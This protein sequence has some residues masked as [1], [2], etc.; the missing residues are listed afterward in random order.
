MK[1]YSKLLGIFSLIT[2]LAALSIISYC[3]FNGKIHR[4]HF[5]LGLLGLYFIIHF[6]I[7]NKLGFKE[8]DISTKAT[9]GLLFAASTLFLIISITAIIPFVQENNQKRKIETLSKLKDFGKDENI[10][11]GTFG[12]LKTKYENDNL[13]Y[14]LA[15]KIPTKQL[16][17]II[18][19]SIQLLDSDGFEI[20]YFKTPDN[21]S[22]NDN[23]KFL[24]AEVT[25][26]FKFAAQN[27]LKIAK[28]KLIVN[29]K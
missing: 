4:N 25:G 26:N 15:L 2:S 21:F 5:N 27:Y 28:W 19:F 17:S 11:T 24:E 7:L 12:Y 20:S 6:L 29:H 10:S 18:D 3:F 8:V 13:Y 22:T 1:T 14:H 16:D 9:K 23:Q